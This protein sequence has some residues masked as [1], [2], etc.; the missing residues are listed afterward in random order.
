MDGEG[1][2]QDY[3]L[4]F[5]PDNPEAKVDL[6]KNLVAMANAGG[7][8]IVFGRDEISIF[9]LDK[10][11]CQALDSARLIDI[12]TRYIK[13]AQIEIS[14]EIH[15]ISGSYIL[16]IYVGA[17][18]YPIVMSR[19]GDWKGMNSR[20]ERP[21]FLQGDIWIRHGS[22]TERITFEDMRAWFEQIRREERE[23]I[24]SRITHLVNL[25]DNAEIQI[26]SDRQQPI[27]SPQRLLEYATL[28]HEYDSNHLLTASDLIYLFLNRY[29]LQ[30]I[31][32][33][34]LRLLIASALRRPPTLYWWLLNTDDEPHLIIEELEKCFEAADRDKS[35]AA[36]SIV[37][38][39]AIF[40]TDTQLIDFL[41]KLCTSRYKH[42]R[43]AAENWQG[44][45]STLKQICERIREEKINDR[46]L[47]QL[48]T[49]ELE[50][51][52]TTI[53]IKVQ[54]QQRTIDSRRLG[55]I[56]RVI[57]SKKSRFAGKVLDGLGNFYSP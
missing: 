14:H 29:T 32:R 15:Q 35:D 10:A 17:A 33:D 6:V 43:K 36:R 39:A 2:Q 38:L 8:Q 53:A 56:T 31:K 5:D 37:E 47:Y 20:K 50:D 41:R 52:A 27:D 11:T 4:M 42:F 54:N 1:R 45:E 34:Q 49:E 28:R 13:P 3:K 7:G 21:L 12:V 9:G 22:K 26:V 19:K 48:S 23:R 16:T 44:R 55:T 57:W 40:A 25:P 51:L 24:L 46:L 18:K 30:D